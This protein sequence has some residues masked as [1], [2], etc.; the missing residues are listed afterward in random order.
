MEERLGVFYGVSVGPGDPELL[1]VKACRV[2][3]ACPVIAA[4]QS[5]GRGSSWRCPLRARRWTWTGKRCCPCPSPC[6]G[7]RRFWRPLGRKRGLGGGLS[8]PG[9]R[10]GHG[11]AGGCVH[12]LY[13]LLCDGAPETAGVSTQMIPGVTSFAAIAAPVGGEPGGGARGPA[14]SPGLSPGPTG[15]A[16]PAGD[17]NFDEIGAGATAG[18]RCSA[19]KGPAGPRPARGQLRPAGGAGLPGPAGA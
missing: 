10:R 2:L 9:S 11:R 7:T 3:K 1:T 18:A 6:R 8:G 19:R 14:R 15:G 13:V 17:E 4:P 5:P 16:G 12:L